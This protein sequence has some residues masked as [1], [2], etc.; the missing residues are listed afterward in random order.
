MAFAGYQTKNNSHW[1]IY[2]Y[3][4]LLFL[5]LTSLCCCCRNLPPPVPAAAGYWAL[6]HRLVLRLR[7]TYTGFLSLSTFQ[8]V[9][10]NAVLRIR[11]RRIHMFSDLPDP[12]PL[13]KWSGSIGQ[14][15]GSGSGY[16]CH[17]A[18]IVRKT[19]IPTVSW[20]LINIPSKSNSRKT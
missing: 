15:S 6:L 8:V 5:V 13:V 4:I 18:K 17:Q 16:F 14:W 11:I 7:G 1:F 3:F 19:L 12:D 9:V 2:D 20:R 10:K